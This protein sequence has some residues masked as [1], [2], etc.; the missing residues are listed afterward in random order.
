MVLL[1]DGA[2]IAPWPLSSCVYMY[3]CLYACLHVYRTMY[4]HVHT[5]AY[6][7]SAH[8]YT[9]DLNEFTIGESSQ[10][11]PRV[12]CTCTL[13]NSYLYT[14]YMYLALVPN[15]VRVSIKTHVHFYVYILQYHVICLCT[16]L[17]TYMY[18][19]PMVTLCRLIPLQGS[20]S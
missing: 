17:S 13:H 16:R 6:I 11:I 7:E 12:S 18:A 20:L 8:M 19:C 5:L 2:F 10:F 15:I 3:V 14:T 1:Q 9:W 4:V